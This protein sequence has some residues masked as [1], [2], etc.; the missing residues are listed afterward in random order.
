MNPN[1]SEILK[2]ALLCAAFSFQAQAKTSIADF[3]SVKQTATDLLVQKKKNQ[4][5]QL[6]LNYSKMPASSVYK[7]E[8]NELLVNVAQ[9]FI[10]KEA[11]ESYESSINMTLENPKEA[12]KNNDHCLSIEPQQLDCL[13][14]RARLLVRQK[15]LKAAGATINEIKE[16]VPG[17]RYDNWLSMILAKKENEFKNRQILKGMPDKPNE[18]GFVLVLLEMERAFLAKN[19]SRAK[20]LILYLE[21][22]HAD[23]PDILFYKYK[24]DQESVE[25]KT[26]PAAEALLLYSNKCKSLNKTITRKFR[27]DFELCVRS[28]K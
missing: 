20:D 22:N 27:Y 4:A 13:I 9:K 17:S 24:I 11:Q 10:S 19:Y 26:K 7:S 1:F 6:L 21:K 15:N 14:Q 8:I 23:W 2:A 18:E 12:I 28:L 3:E 5:I 16:L 25:E